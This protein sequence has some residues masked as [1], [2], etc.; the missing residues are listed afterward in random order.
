MNILVVDD[1]EA[2]R[3]RLVSLLNEI[4]G[5]R[6]VGQAASVAEATRELRELKPDA[7]ILDLRLPDGTGLDVLRLLQCE[8]I[9]TAAIVLT[10]H[11]L[12]Q[13]E[14]HALAAGAHAFLNKAKD[15]NKVVDLVRTLM[16]R[17]DGAP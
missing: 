11:P 6:I 1:A 3:A 13:Y 8:R 2:I 16:G 5:V 12:P 7:M 10:N 17:G 9:P 14:K 4:A 15:F